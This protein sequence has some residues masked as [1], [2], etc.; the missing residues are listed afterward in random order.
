[1]EAEAERRLAKLAV[2]PEMEQRTCVRV[3][4]SVL[5]PDTNVFIDHCEA[6]DAICGSGDII[7]LV[8][9][10]GEHWH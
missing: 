9:L 6:I 1:M 10:I 2:R 3:R 7:I 8:P 4:P 5:V